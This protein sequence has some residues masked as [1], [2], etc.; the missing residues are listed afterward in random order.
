MDE[1]G[2]LQ[3]DI[4]EGALHARQHAHDAAQIDIAHVAALDAALYM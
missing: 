2:A 4:D 1:G 3:A